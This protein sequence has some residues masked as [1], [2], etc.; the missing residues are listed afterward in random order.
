MAERARGNGA[1]GDS[2]QDA[3]IADINNHIL[4]NIEIEVT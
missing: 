2:Y 4:Q 3:I 1:R